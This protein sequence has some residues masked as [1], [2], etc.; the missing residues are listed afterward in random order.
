M[1]PCGCQTLSVAHLYDLRRLWPVCKLAPVSIRPPGDLELY[2]VLDA[3]RKGEPGVFRK[4]DPGF[5]IL[6]LKDAVVKSRDEALS[7]EC[8]PGA[9]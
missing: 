5:C 8:L 1:L 9:C 3:F 7:E 6:V 2:L 4:A